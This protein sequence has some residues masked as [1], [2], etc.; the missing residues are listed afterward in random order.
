ME[1]S[2]C[3]AEGLAASLVLNASRKLF[4]LTLQVRL[5]LLL[6]EEETERGRRG[7]GGEGQGEEDKRERKSSSPKWFFNTLAIAFLLGLHDI[8][9][10]MHVLSESPLD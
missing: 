4:F 9:L 8:S 6:Q 5:C 7:G 10:D 3:F 2:L 1:R